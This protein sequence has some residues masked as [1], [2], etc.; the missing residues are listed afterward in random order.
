M[1]NEEREITISLNIPL[2]EFIQRVEG[3][4]IE[5]KKEVR[6]TDNYFDT[7]DWSLYKNAAA[8]RLRQV[9]DIDQALAFKK[10]FYLPNRDNKFFIEEI[11]DKLPLEDN[12]KLKDI[13]YRV[14]IDADGNGVIDADEI[15][16]VLKEN[17]FQGEQSMSKTRQ[18]FCDRNENDIVI[19][20]VDKVGTIIEL[21]CH[22]DEPL[23]MVKNLLREDEWVRSHIGTSYI[24]L[25]KVKGFNN[26]LEYETK[27]TESPDWN[28]LEREREMYDDLISSSS[29]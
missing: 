4:G 18:L 1:A 7:D 14:G 26:H 9:D 23:D 16:N 29:L 12:S 8:L 20:D 13:F 3:V 21:E 25:E 10:M 19:D 17:G 22:N 2:A 6:Q 11:E 27:F 28:V 5:K 24:W 15:R